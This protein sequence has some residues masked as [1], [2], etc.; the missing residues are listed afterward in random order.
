MGGTLGPA[1]IAREHYVFCVLS[2]G[3]FSIIVAQI[4]MVKPA[5]PC[6]ATVSKKA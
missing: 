1:V 3:L 6:A 5:N 4:K 2:H